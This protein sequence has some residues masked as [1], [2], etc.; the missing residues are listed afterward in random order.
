[1]KLNV[2][3]DERALAV[4]VPPH[5]LHEA[6]DFYRKMDSDMDH[7]WQMGPEFIE[8]PD[9]VQRCQIAANKLLTSLS[10]ANETMITL[11]AGYILKRVPG[12]TGVRI[13]TGGEMLHTELLY[14]KPLS[15]PTTTLSQGTPRLQKL[16][17]IEAMEQAGKD[18]TK[19]YQVGKSHRFAVRDLK[20]GEWL[21]SGPMQTEQE[22]YEKRMQAYKRRL[23]ELTGQ[24]N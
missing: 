12:V 4:D 17:K 24:K 3:V 7:G 13:D 11:M 9:K 6:E 2:I 22:A 5:M 16:G 20:T 19:V 21:E 23:D 1:M 14:E 15:P 8:K 10:A 18:V